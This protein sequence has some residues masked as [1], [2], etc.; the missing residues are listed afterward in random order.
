MAITF[1]LK[2]T[3][4]YSEYTGAYVDGVSQVEE[5]KEDSF[6]EQTFQIIVFDDS[7]GYKL[8][9]QIVEA[10]DKATA[11]RWIRSHGYKLTRQDISDKNVKVVKMHH[12]YKNR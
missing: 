2:N 4:F 6:V 10:K 8:I 11:V 9:Q 12:M 7:E 1:E 5:F 3:K